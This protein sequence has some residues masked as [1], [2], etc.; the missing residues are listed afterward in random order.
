[1]SSD[2]NMVRPKYLNKIED[3]D[4]LSSDQQEQ[5]SQVTEKY[6][7]RSNDYYLSLIDWSDP[8][9][10]IRRIIVPDLCELREWGSLDPSDEQ[11]ITVLPGV[12]HKYSSTVVFLVVN[13]C[14]GICRY[15][16]RKRVFIKDHSEVLSD[17]PAAVE[18]INQH[19]E[20]TNVLM[21]GGDPLVLA[22]S[23]LEKIVDAV[24]PIE[25][26][27]IIRWGTK[28]PSFNPYRIVNDPQLLKLVGKCLD[29]GKQLYVM[30]HFNHVNEMTDIAIESVKVLRNGGAVLCNQTPIIRGVNDNPQAM[31]DLFRKLSFAGVSPYYVFQCRPSSGNSGYAV[32]IEEGYRVFEQAKANVSGLAKRARFTMS[33]ESGKVEIVGMTAE[34]IY[35]KYHRAKDDKK[36]GSFLIFK[37]NPDA[38]WLDDYGRPI[39]SCSLDSLS[40]SFSLK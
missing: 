4:G 8:D 37:R 14:G 28:M 39:E 9:D 32:P 19:K 29:Y 25:H 6:R 2:H 30:T 17:L 36:S 38:Y 22:T 34:H 20:I 13:V 40:E 24:G 12:E 31:I 27:K 7:F 23:K 21:T 11:G 15:C 10:P 1:M 5:L 16:F 18:Y 3:I 35:M 33:H 26:V